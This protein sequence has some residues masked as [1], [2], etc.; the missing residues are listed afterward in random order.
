[1][2]NSSNNKPDRRDTLL[3]LVG[4]AAVLAV[5]L[6]IGYSYSQ[7]KV[8]VQVV[9]T[10]TP[11]P[12]TQT[13]AQVEPTQV[14]AESTSKDTPTTSAA[15]ENTPASASPT[16]DVMEFLLSDARHFQGSPDAP[17]TMIEF[18]DFK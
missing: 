13:V 5:G 3:W 11:D 14:S 7:S 10:A 2:E 17:V 1:M 4:L 6:T 9:V 8:P 12:E 16:P 15:T 18:S